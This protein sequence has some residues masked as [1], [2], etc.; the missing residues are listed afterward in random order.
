M[1][2]LKTSWKFMPHSRPD[3]FTFLLHLLVLY[4]GGKTEVC[5]ENV[6]DRRTREG[7]TFATSL[8]ALR[9]TSTLMTPI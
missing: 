8:S 4:R 2:L 9:S 3:T 5:E 1:F 6:Q 7:E